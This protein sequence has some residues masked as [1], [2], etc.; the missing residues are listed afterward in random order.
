MSEII[1]EM[2]TEKQITE[3]I[4]QIASQINKDYK[5]K[6]VHLICILKGS[7][8]FCCELAKR[9]E[10]PVTIDFM[11]VSSYGNST[12]SSGRLSVTKDLNEP[13]DGC[14]CIIIEDIID[15]GST[16]SLTKK[17]LFARGPASLKICALL[18]KPDRRKTEIEAEYTGFIVPDKFVV[19]YGLDYA[20]KYRNL[21]YIGEL[22][23]VDE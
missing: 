11:S 15:T 10:V 4:L 12:E 19:G 9:L 22:E 13:I 8:F 14:H 18:D 7:V 16:L 23:F 3:R 5:G 2:I 1:H 17:M 6:E 20:Q 21:P